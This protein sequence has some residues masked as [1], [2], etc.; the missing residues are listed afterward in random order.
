MQIC[1][2]LMHF[3]GAKSVLHCNQRGEVGGRV[4]GWGGLFGIKNI[5]ENEWRR[6]ITL[7]KARLA[8]MNRGGL[9]EPSSPPDRPGP[10]IQ[11]EETKKAKRKTLANETLTETTE[12]GKKKKTRTNILSAF[13]L[14]NCKSH[15]SLS[16]TR[17]HVTTKLGTNKSRIS[18]L[19]W[20]DIFVAPLQKKFVSGFRTNTTE[21]DENWRKLGKRMWA[22]FSTACSLTN[23]NV[24]F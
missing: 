9:P 6:L 17:D 2:L 3:K 21:L 4:A 11:K 18:M 24:V 15:V 8:P 22:K 14:W 5:F 20:C 13:L 1:Q 10:W 12:D 7:W 19:K 16:A 23:D